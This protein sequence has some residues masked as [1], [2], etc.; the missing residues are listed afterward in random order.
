MLRIKQIISGV[1]DKIVKNNP[2]APCSVRIFESD[3]GGWKFQTLNGVQTWGN[4]D[5]YARARY[6]AEKY[7]FII[8][9]EDKK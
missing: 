9:E 4:Y 7:N 8:V 1:L 6:V 5:S 2:D 3:D